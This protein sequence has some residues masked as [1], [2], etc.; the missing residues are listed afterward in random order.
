M[1]KQTLKQKKKNVRSKYWK[2]KADAAWGKLIHL[3]EECAIGLNCN[4]NLE[5]HHL[6]TRANVCTRHNPENG[7]LLCSKHH[8]FSNRLSAHGAPMAFAEW[9]QHN[10]PETYQ[11]CA[12]NKY[13]TGKPD[14]KEALERLE[15]LVE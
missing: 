7:I 10:L 2:T 1:A 14:Y 9:I 15:K 3:R 11:W 13:T 5:A 12:E 8:K 6:I 4:G